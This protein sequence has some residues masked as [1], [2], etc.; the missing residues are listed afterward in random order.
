MLEVVYVWE[1]VVDY[2]C[3]QVL[4]NVGQLQLFVSFIIAK[5]LKIK[6]IFL[7]F[8]K[9]YWQ[10]YFFKSNYNYYRV[11]YVVFLIGGIVVFW[12]FILIFFRF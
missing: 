1:E 8:I 7:V 3:G 2:F 5:S 9:N 11:I 12:F 4:Q 6:L 10:M